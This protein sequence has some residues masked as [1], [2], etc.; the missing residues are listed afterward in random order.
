MSRILLVTFIGV[1][2]AGKTTFA[3]QLA[4]KL[5]GVTLNSDAMR[6]AIF[7][8]R[9]K[10]D[11][12]YH[13]DDRQTLNTYTFGA[14]DYVTKNL[15]ASGVP[16]VYDAIQRTHS[17][18]DHLQQ[19]ASECS[20]RYV[21]VHITTDHEVAVQRGLERADRDNSRRFTTEKTMREVVQHFHDELEPIRDGETVIEISGEIPFKGQYEAFVNAVEKHK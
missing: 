7:G 20:A 18:R 3:T 13:S 9:E 12:I 1:P 2:G 14:I 11:A 19:L 10:T 15:L 16:V 21:F 8:S 6:M 4:E 5:G 17:D